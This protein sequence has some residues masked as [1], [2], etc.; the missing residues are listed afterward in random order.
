MKTDKNCK[1]K[2][3]EV[4]REKKAVICRLI[5]SRALHFLPGSASHRTRPRRSAWTPVSPL[6]VEGGEKY[7]IQT[8]IYACVH[9]YIHIHIY[10]HIFVCVCALTRACLCVFVY[11]WV[12]VSTLTHMH[13]YL[14]VYGCI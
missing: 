12:S 7:I 8:P 5:P 9:T 6:E 14:G 3:A 13:V 2:R 10:A 1:T 11:V 4:M